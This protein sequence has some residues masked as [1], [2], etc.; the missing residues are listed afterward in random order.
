MRNHGE[1]YVE[2]R[3]TQT[4]IKS[5]HFF[6]SNRCS[7]SLPSPPVRP[8]P[9][10]SVT[11]AY[12][13]DIRSHW[14]QWDGPM[15]RWWSSQPLLAYLYLRWYS[16]GGLNGKQN[17]MLRDRLLTRSSPKLE[18]G[19]QAFMKLASAHL[20]WGALTRI[21]SSNSHPHKFVNCYA[22]HNILQGVETIAGGINGSTEAKKLKLFGWSAH[23]EKDLARLYER[24][25]IVWPIIW[26]SLCHSEGVTSIGSH[27]LLLQR[28]RNY[29]GNW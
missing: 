26:G 27:G 17:Y 13:G 1:V 3:L 21:W 20:V 5:G 6:H 16:Y 4:S 22:E 19:L 10:S 24:T 12:G 8:R 7:F 9:W 18:K 15:R 2:S 11:N 28:W 23:D 14:E 25:T 29:T